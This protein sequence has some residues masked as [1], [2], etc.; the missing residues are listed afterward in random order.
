[1]KT[2]RHIIPAVLAV[3]ALA[4]SCIGWEGTVSEGVTVPIG[5]YGGYYNPWWGVGSDIYYPIGPGVPPPPPPPP[6]IQGPQRPPAQA[7]NIRPGV[8][9]P[10]SPGNRPGNN[11]GPTFTPVGP[12]NRPGNNGLPTVTS[13]PVSNTPATSHRGR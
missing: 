12:S 3:M 5:G 8:N 9:G 7:P 10:S 11:G 1:M 6:L 4:T 2:Y 13:M